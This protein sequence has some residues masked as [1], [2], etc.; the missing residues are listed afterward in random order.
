MAS[1][2]VFEDPK[3]QF[4]YDKLEVKL[5]FAEELVFLENMINNLYSPV[6]FCHNDLLAGNIMYD[7]KNNY[8]CFIDYEYGSYNFRGYDIGNHFCEQTII[9]NVEEY[10]HFI[11]D[12][13][14]YP[15]EENQRI[16]FSSYIRKIKEIQGLDQE[17]LEEEIIKLSKEVEIFVLASHFLWSCWAIIQASTSEIEFGYL[18]FASERMKDYFRR[19]ALLCR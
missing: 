9:Y 11:I 12:P 4:I 2:L 5:K 14:L 6:V 8:V 7:E 17:V 3:K 10:P 19:K 16:F 18:E 1:S 15:S 13:S